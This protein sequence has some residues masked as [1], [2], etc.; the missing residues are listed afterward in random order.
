MGDEPSAAEVP[1]PTLGQSRVMVVYKDDPVQKLQ[2]DSIRN[3]GAEF[4]DSINGMK[5]AIEANQWAPMNAEQARLFA[6]AFTTIEEA[7]MWSIKAITK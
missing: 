3:I 6:L 2:I 5:S 1:S 4:I 7:V